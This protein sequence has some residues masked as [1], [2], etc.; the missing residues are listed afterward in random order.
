MKIINKIVGA[1][2]ASFVFPR[3]T[4]VLVKH[5]TRL[6]SKTGN[7]LDIG[8]G[9][10]LIAKKIITNNPE[11]KITCVDIL[12]RRYGYL[13]IVL[14]DGVHIPYPD[15]SFDCVMLVDVIHHTTSQRKLLKE[16]A[17]VSKKYLLIK[18][19]YADSYLKCTLLRCLDWVGNKAHGISLPYS[20]LSRAQWQEIWR[21]L[22]LE[23]ELELRRLNIY[24]FPF[25]RLIEWPWN[26]IV[27]LRKIND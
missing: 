1:C 19:H 11:L 17:R 25:N 18:D 16:A 4:E 14:F 12:E 13:P 15:K 2:H 21:K 5:L 7:I 26:F 24:P 9:D 23:Q 8:S 3:R 20:F 10:G 22:G 27:K 6:L